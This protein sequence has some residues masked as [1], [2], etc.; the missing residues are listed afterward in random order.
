MKHHLLIAEDDRA[1]ADRLSVAARERGYEVTAVEDPGSLM[2]QANTLLP[3]AIVLSADLPKGRGWA[4]CNELKRN[5]LLRHQPLV[6]T[7]SGDD[8][9]AV[10]EQHRRLQ[11]RA[12]IYLAK[13]YTEDDLI[14]HIEPLLAEPR[15]EMLA[16]L[17][18]LREQ[19]PTL[20]SGK[21]FA[22]WFAIAAAIAGAVLAFYLL[23]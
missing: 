8:A 15:R 1:L 4:L 20:S 21:F 13:P 5:P 19:T 11:T 9:Q 18:R 12:D 17:Y 7:A 3:S 22:L 2:T 14:A 10:F 6:L 23:R 16:R